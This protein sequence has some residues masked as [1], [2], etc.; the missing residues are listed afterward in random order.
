MSSQ[1]YPETAGMK[2]CRTVAGYTSKGQIRNT[3][4]KEKLN[5]VYC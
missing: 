1:F 5:I 4:I 2:F 3:K